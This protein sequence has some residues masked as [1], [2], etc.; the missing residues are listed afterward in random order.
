MIVVMSLPG[1]VVVL[2]LGYAIKRFLVGGG[3]IQKRGEGEAD[4]EMV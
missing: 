2:G 4:R 3:Q 1:V